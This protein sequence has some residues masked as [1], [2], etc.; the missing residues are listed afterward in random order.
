VQLAHH[1]AICVVSDL[2]CGYST[3]ILQVFTFFAAIC[4]GTGAADI[5]GLAHVPATVEVGSLPW[6]GVT[7]VQL[8]N[9]VDS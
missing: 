5:L 6:G 3:F 2:F 4:V 1:I 9:L 8:R 7:A